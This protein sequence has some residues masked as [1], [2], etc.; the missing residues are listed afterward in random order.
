MGSGRPN[1]VLARLEHFSLW[2]QGN[3]QSELTLCG[4]LFP[5]MSTFEKDEKMM[6]SMCSLYSK[7]FFF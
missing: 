4:Y 7:Y 5:G 6:N 1:A 3:K 2:G